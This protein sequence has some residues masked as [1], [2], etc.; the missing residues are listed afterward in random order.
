MFIT[1]HRIY[2]LLAL[3]CALFFLS[4]L[5]LP[6]VHSEEETQTTTGTASTTEPI[7]AEPAVEVSLKNL[8]KTE[9]IPG[10]DSVIGDFVVGPG[11]VDL[12]IEPG[13]SKVVEMTV[14]NRTGE[15]RRFN[16]TIE[17]AKGSMDTG[18][19]I[20]LL[21]SDR[22]PYS[23]KDYVKVPHKS[24]E[25]EHNQR[26]RI[27]VTIT[28]PP[29]A[30]PGGLYGSVLIDTVA[31]D[32]VEGNTG[33]TAPKSA[34]VAR[35]GTLFFVTIPGGISKDGGLKDF[36]T[37]P[38]KR[39]Y[40]SSPITFGLLYENNGSI[41]LAPYGEMR[42]KNMFGEDVGSVNIDPWFVLPQSLR[43]RE[44]TWD[45]EFL[46]G[47]YTAT[48]LVNRSY[49]DIID[50][51]SYTFWVLPWKPLLGI[52]AALFLVIFLIKAFFKKFEFKRKQ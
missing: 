32:A 20:V 34:V 21:G 45:R 24:F 10:G 5:P 25:L 1:V 12:T 52:F 28:L 13:K 44:V 11:K 49:D 16:V 43:L 3:C 51:M 8:Y 15:P 29:D 40:Q 19:S 48:V 46:F 50:E 30:E 47:M 4:A 39:F 9:G 14:T 37:V 7:V 18:T 33:G 22:G 2:A 35:I 26:A 27:P 36:G 42:I 17:D 6:V 31:V 23:M 41:H 38:E